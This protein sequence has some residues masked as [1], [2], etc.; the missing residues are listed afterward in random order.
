LYRNEAGKPG[1]RVRLKGPAGNPA[2][3]GA[4]LWLTHGG[5]LGPAREIRAG[6][7]YW[8][9]DSVVPVLAATEAAAR[10]SIRWPG[11]KTVSSD[12]PQGAKEVAVDTAGKVVVAR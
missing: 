7:G 12:I 6:S 8:S 3:V 1:L 5:Q 11:G 4:V 2:G 10:L 9:Q